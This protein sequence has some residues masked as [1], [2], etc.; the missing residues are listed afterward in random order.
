MY[1]IIFEE[2]LE[3]EDITFNDREREYQEINPEVSYY[4]LP[5]I[6]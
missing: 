3:L 5:I 6:L 2:I 1:E 4:Q